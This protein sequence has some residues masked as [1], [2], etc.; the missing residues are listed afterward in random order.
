M[1][2][3]HDVANAV[4][5]QEPLGTL[6]V[7]RGLITD[8]QLADALE[9]Q[10]TSGEQLGAILVARGYAPPALVA[11]ALATQHGGMLKT[12]YGF[13]TG[14]GRGAALAEVQVAAPP[15]SI[16]VAAAPASAAAA[17]SDRE[18]VRSELELAS[19]ESTRLAEANARLSALRAELEQNLA[20]ETQ[21]SASLERELAEL[22]STP[23]SV[24][25]DLGA[26]QESNAQL[27]AALTQW[28]AAYVELEQRLAQA[29]ARADASDEQRPVLETRLQEAVE[30]LHEAAVA[31]GTLEAQLEAMTAQAASLAAAAAESA[32]WAEAESHLVFF[33][34]SEGYELAELDGPP[35]PE[36]AQVELPALPMQTVSRIGR[37]PFRGDSLPCAYLVAT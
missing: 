22:R 28:Q 9:E 16:A 34:G 24:A 3:E 1:S 18:A 26:W 19:S 2:A 15:L 4:T 23:V 5:P 17:Q 37:S 25:D 21:R 29:T 11:Q 30:G 13:A 33:Q 14:F 36:G 35:P 10:R 31:R 20:R 32:P 7:E 27:D 6:L 8:A 12:E